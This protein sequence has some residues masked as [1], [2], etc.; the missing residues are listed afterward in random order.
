M[1]KFSVLFALIVVWNKKQINNNGPEPPF[2]F[3]EN[4]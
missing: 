1:L 3:Y 2:T 4:I